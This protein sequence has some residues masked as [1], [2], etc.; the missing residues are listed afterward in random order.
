MEKSWK[1]KKESLIKDSGYYFPQKTDRLKS[2]RAIAFALIIS[3]HAFIIFLLNHQLDLKVLGFADNKNPLNVFKQKVDIKTHNELQ[4]EY[5]ASIDAIKDRDMKIAA[6]EK[7]VEQILDSRRDNIA[8]LENQIKELKKTKFS[9]IENMENKLND[10]NRE[11]FQKEQNTTLAIQAHA[12]RLEQKDL[13]IK[14]LKEKLLA[15]DDLSKEK[16]AKVIKQD[17]L[18]QSMREKID[19]LSALQIETSKTKNKQ[20]QDLNEKIEQTK[21]ENSIKVANVEKLVK[22]KDRLIDRQNK[23]IKL[24]KG[25]LDKLIEELKN[26]KM[27]NVQLTTQVKQ[28]KEIKGLDQIQKEINKLVDSD[29]SINWDEENKHKTKVEVVASKAKTESKTQNNSE[30]EFQQILRELKN[31]EIKTAKELKK[32]EKIEKKK[33]KTLKAKEAKSEKVLAQKKLEIANQRKLRGLETEGKFSDGISDSK[34]NLTKPVEKKKE[35]Q[36]IANPAK[37]KTNKANT[38]TVKRNVTNT[39]SLVPAPVTMTKPFKIYT[40]KVHVVELNENIGLISSKY[41]N[42]SKRLD[43]IQLANPDLNIAEIEVGQKIVIP[44]IQI[45]SVIFRNGK[46]YYAYPE[47]RKA[48]LQSK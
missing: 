8:D 45:E 13:E 5:D 15:F 23:K 24:M 40:E 41:Y 25:N 6:L 3:T 44:N 19:K 37:K 10:F 43:I 1:S 30:K 31:K 39:P 38:K 20:I 26:E 12:E 17:E 9:L 33:E 42:T 11:L 46:R 36:L 34:L 22:E 2:S 27:L 48:L 28:K 21:V 35:P 16:N 4:K 47:A 32:I 14:L 18:I 29:S 7:Q